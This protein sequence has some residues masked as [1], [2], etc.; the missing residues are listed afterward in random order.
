M[1]KPVPGAMERAKERK[2]SRRVLAW[3]RAQPEGHKATAAQIAQGIGYTRKL[4]VLRVMLRRLEEQGL[5]YNQRGPSTSGHGS[6]ASYW[7][8]LPFTAP[9]LKEE[10]EEDIELLPPRTHAPEIKPRPGMLFPGVYASAE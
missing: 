1:T 7:S 5:V 9:P 6:Y 2:P 10:Q 8:S 3:L 4:D